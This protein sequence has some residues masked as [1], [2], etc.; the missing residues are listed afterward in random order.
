MHTGDDLQPILAPEIAVRFP[1]DPLPW[2]RGWRHIFERLLLATYPLRTS[3]Y[4]R[5]HLLLRGCGW[6]RH[7]YS[8]IRFDGDRQRP[9][10]GAPEVERQ[11]MATHID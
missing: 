6:C 9:P 7:D 3:A 10:I 2:L 4:N 11:R 1:R 5:R 8:L